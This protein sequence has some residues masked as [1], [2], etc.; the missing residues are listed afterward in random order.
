MM[1]I[2]PIALYPMSSGSLVMA[3]KPKVFLYATNYG[4]QAQTDPGTGVPVR[5]WCLVDVR[6]FTNLAGAQA[7]PDLLLLPRMWDSELGA[8]AAMIQAALASKFTIGITLMP[9]NTYRDAFNLIGRLITAD[10]DLDRFVGLTRVM[11][12][13]SQ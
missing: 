3:Y 6:H 10:F 4:V 7:D 11:P 9:T 8:Q 1:V 12:G 5:T 2:C 13:G